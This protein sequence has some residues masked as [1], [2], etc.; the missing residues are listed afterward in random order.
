MIKQD[1]KLMDW[2]E[3]PPG[4]GVAYSLKSSP[5]KYVSIMSLKPDARE[6]AII[7]FMQ[8]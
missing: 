8:K 2:G 7:R 6:F 3:T 5:D 4:W 1:F